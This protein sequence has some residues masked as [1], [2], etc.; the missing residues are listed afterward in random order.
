VKTKI[1]F[2]K[3][4]NKYH[5]KKIVV[6]GEK[7]DSEKE[8]MRFCE[9][10]LLKRS[11]HIKDLQRQ[12]KFLLIPAQYETVETGEYYKRGS[13]KG[14]AKTKQVC[15]EQQV[16]YKADFVYQQD[17]KTVVEDTKGVRT[18]DYIIK[19]KLMLWVH[20]IKIKEVC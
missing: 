19:R 14:Q 17:G 20:K 15:V 12:V 1:R 7:F 3:P 4:A 10:K 16:V 9:L 11:G 13:K 18:T 5:S 2:P 8:Y 6:N